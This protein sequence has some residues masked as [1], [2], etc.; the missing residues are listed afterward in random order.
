M[1]V[2]RNIQAEIDTAK[3]T[4]DLSKFKKKGFVKGALIVEYQRT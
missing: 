2:L 3:K 1:N 4:K